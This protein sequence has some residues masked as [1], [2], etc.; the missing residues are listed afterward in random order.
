MLL[1]KEKYTQKPQYKNA[2]KTRGQ[3]K[4]LSMATFFLFAVF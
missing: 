1:G 4:N 2:R 3:M